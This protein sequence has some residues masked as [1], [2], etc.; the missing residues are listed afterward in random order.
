MTNMSKIIK[1]H[2]KN[3]TSKPRD[4]GPKCNCRKKAE[5]QMEGNCL[6]I[7]VVYK[8]DVIRPMSKKVY[9]EIAEG[10]WKNRFNYHK[11]SFEQK[12]YFNRTTHSS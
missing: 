12:R 7:Y 2:N 3:V 4:Q 11:L 8:C 1:E 10:E 5:C 9:L 6:V